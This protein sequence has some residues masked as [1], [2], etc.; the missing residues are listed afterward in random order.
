MN[1]VFHLFYAVASYLAFL[2]SFLAMMAATLGIDRFGVRAIDGQPR[3]APVTA[4]VIDL[5]LIVAF[6]LQHSVMARRGF[7]AAFG[8]W[9]PSSVERNTYVLASALAVA[10]HRPWVEPHRRQGLEFRW[11]GA[12]LGASWPLPARLCANGG[13]FFRN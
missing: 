11:T 9:L 5:G 7:K 8:R 1:R 2:A 6:G 12:T 3:H 4:A 13:E 10:G